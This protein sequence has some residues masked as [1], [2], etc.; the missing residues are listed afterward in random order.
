MWNKKNNE[1]SQGNS[2]VW[3]NIGSN[4]KNMEKKENNW[5]SQFVAVF[6]SLNQLILILGKKPNN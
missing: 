3:G 4:R 6:Y 2:I 1:V 5:Q